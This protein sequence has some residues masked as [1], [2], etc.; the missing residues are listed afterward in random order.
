MLNTCFSAKR[1]SPVA[2]MERREERVVEEQEGKEMPG[3][4][5]KGERKEVSKCERVELS[6]CERVVDKQ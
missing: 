1:V 4:D 6:K 2:R 3:K 5:R